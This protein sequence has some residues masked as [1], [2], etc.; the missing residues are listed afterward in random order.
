MNTDVIKVH[1]GKEYE[2][3]FPNLHRVKKVGDILGAN[4]IKDGLEKIKWEELYDNEKKILESFKII[5]KTEI[6]DSS[7]E[8]FTP[9]D[10]QL[11]LYGFFLRVKRASVNVSEDMQTLKDIINHPAGKSVP[12]GMSSTSQSIPVLTEI[13]KS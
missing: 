2:F 12:M 13:P 7:I 4:L 11:V 10:I 6:T 8:D 3:S 9:A 1:N 5:F